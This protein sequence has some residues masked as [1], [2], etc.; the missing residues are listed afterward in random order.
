MYH[1]A[2]GPRHLDSVPLQWLTR[3]VP[4]IHLHVI[5]LPSVSF[6]RHSFFRIKVS[7]HQENAINILISDFVTYQLQV[8][9]IQYVTDRISAICICYLTCLF[10]RGTIVTL[11]TILFL[12]IQMSEQAVYQL[13]NVQKDVTIHLSPSTA[14]QNARLH[15]LTQVR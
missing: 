12:L 8:L 3:F 15:W 9:P 13:H 11:T 7:L 4:Y 1:P 6:L 10:R 5:M 14:R 2:A